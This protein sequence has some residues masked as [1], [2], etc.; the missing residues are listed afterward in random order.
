MTTPE[1]DDFLE[2]FFDDAKKSAPDVPDGL[3]AR[4]MA[5][6][7]AETDR[8]VQIASAA[9]P[10]SVWA[11][12]LGAVG[13]WPALAGLSAATLTGVW[14]G[15]NPPAAVGNTLAQVMGQDGAAVSDYMFDPISGFELAMLEG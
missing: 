4:I 8:R 10:K 7:Q 3:M 6:A 14:I 13:G 11:Q 9:A 5:D 15:L 12:I 2:A 1:N